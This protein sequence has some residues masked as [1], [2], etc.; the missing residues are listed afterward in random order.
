MKYRKYPWHHMTIYTYLT[1]CHHDKDLTKL[2]VKLKYQY[3]WYSH[4]IDINMSS[5]M[6]DLNDATL[7]S[8]K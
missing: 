6:W 5:F 2:L 8:Y 7:S 3:I 4:I 1:Q